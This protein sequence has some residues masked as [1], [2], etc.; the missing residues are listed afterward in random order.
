M[1]RKQNIQLSIPTPC[2]ENWENMTQNEKGRHCANCNKTVIDFSLFTDKQ[3][4]EFLN[5]TTGKIC[6]HISSWQLNRELVYVEPRNHFLYKLLFGTALTFGIAGSAN[7]NYNPNQKPL[8]EQ[9]AESNAEQ[10]RNIKTAK[11][12]GTHLTVTVI[13]DSTKQVLPYAEV[14][15]AGISGQSSQA[16]ADVNGKAEIYSLTPG[17][18]DIISHYNGYADYKKRITLTKSSKTFV[19]RIKRQ[20]IELIPHEMVNGGLEIRQ[21]P[22]DTIKPNK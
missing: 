19:I 12:T 4:I 15:L 7:A 18:Y 2:T 9:Y 3:L 17:K 21:I 13:D 6:G 5:K 11:D 22:E 14:I 20:S 16:Q 8:V 1:Q 10:N